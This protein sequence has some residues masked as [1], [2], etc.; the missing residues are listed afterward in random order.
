MTTKKDLPNFHDA[1]DETIKAIEAAKAAGGEQD[2]LL[3]VFRSKMY[4]ESLIAK[5]DRQALLRDVNAAFK[6]TFTMNQVRKANPALLRSVTQE[7]KEPSL[8]PVDELHGSVEI[9]AGAK[10]GD[11]VAHVIEHVIKEDQ[12]KSSIVGGAVHEISDQEM[13]DFVNTLFAAGF[14]E[15]DEDRRA[16]I[17]SIWMAAQSKE[18]LA[19]F[20]TVQQQMRSSNTDDKFFTFLRTQSKELRED[21]KE[22]VLH[23]IE[24]DKAPTQTADNQPTETAQPAPAVAAPA[25]EH[26]DMNNNLKDFRDA[27]SVDTNAA[28]PTTTTSTETNTSEK[29]TSMKTE[30]VMSFVAGLVVFGYDSD[31]ARG[32]L[33]QEFIKLHPKFQETVSAQPDTLSVDETFFKACESNSELEETF[34]LWIL[35]KHPD[36]AKKI[37]EQAMGSSGGSTAPKSRYSIMGDRDE[38]VRSSWVAV[39]SAL[40][41]GALEMG[42]AGQI[43]VGAGVGTLVGAGASFF[44]AEQ[45]DKHIEGQFGRY[46]AAGMLGMAVGALGSKAGRFIEGKVVGAGQGVEGSAADVP[47]LPVPAMPATAAFGIKGAAAGL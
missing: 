30:N 31:K 14:G 9:Q 21:F 39:G 27:T 5:N 46:V 17:Y 36:I 15:Y 32:E 24:L 28:N 47:S 12:L 11:D 26:T 8:I 19:Q 16:S 1:A 25:L 40:V 43:T 13:L 45:T 23:K 29:A 37:A 34:T 38:G 2:M 7:H 3:A 33:F 41:G 22:V 4:D 18:V 10:G 6:T 35:A 20:L 42:H 44:L